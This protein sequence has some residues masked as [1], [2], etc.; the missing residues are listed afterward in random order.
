MCLLLAGSCLPALPHAPRAVTRCG[1]GATYFDLPGSARQSPNGLGRPAAAGRDPMAKLQT[2]KPRV[3]VQASRLAAL[4]VGTPRD[5]GRPWRRRRAAWLYA[6]PWCCM[7]TA[8]GYVTPATQVDH[9]IPLWKG[10][11][12]DDSNM[13]S[14]CDPHHEAKTSSE[15]TE[16]GGGG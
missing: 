1:I 11:R 12:D 10:G 2:L 3:Q 7:C 16:R 6:H 13:Q 4:Q 5:N 8:S 14:L 15:A 9:V